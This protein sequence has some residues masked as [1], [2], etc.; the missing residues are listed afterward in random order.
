[1]SGAQRRLLRDVLRAL[2]GHITS[3]LEALNETPIDG[4]LMPSIAESEHLLCMIASHPAE[5][6]VK[7]EVR[8]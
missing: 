6:W 5:A 2:K 7:A 3:A 1:M 8:E 4:G